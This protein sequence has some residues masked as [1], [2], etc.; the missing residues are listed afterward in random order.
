MAVRN[1]TTGEQWV[2][3]QGAN[4]QIYQWVDNGSK[5]L[6][7]E[8]LGEAAAPGSSPMTVRNPTTGEQWVYYQ[9]A[10]GQMYQWLDN[11][12]EWKNYGIGGEGF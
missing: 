2:Y 1:P 11:V 12:L 9:G 3:Y 8:L 7:V 10:N 6:N 4:G 5:W